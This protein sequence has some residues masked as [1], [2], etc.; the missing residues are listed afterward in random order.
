MDDNTS[1]GGMTVFVTLTYNNLSIPVFS[2]VA[3]A[4]DY[5]S[6]EIYSK[7]YTI[8]CFSK[9]HKDAFEN[10][11]RKYFER[12]GVTGKSCGSP[13]RFFWASEYGMSDSGTHRPHYHLLI[14]FP[15]D[16]LNVLKI[17]QSFVTSQKLKDLI[18]DCWKHGFC[19]WSKPSAGGMFV[20]SVFACTYVSKYV[21]KDI[22]F[23]D[24]PDLKEYLSFPDLIEA[25]R[26]FNLVKDRFPR[27][28]QSKSFG[29]G[30]VDLC[31]NDLVFKDGIN[32][33]F[34]KD[35]KF[36]KKKIYKV[37]RYI[38]RKLLYK[39]DEY[40]S[41]VLNERG[42]SVKKI[43]LSFHDKVDLLTK[44][45]SDYFN[46]DYIVSR[47]SNDLS[48]FNSFSKRSFL[49]PESIISEFKYLLDGRSYKELALY[50]LVYQ[51]TIVSTNKYFDKWFI[52]NFN[53]WSVEKLYKEGEYL[54]NLRVD[55]YENDDFY[56]EDG[57]MNVLNKEKFLVFDDFE[58]FSCLDRFNCL[59]LQLENYYKVSRNTKYLEDKKKRAKFKFKIS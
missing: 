27:H 20:R 29:L 16:Y 21:V 6:G 11:L 17:D 35:V 47:V 30:L 2:D 5:E 14:F 7:L 42:K 19:R 40:G 59:A 50:T 9:R 28:W 32:L 52:K 53:S 39:V 54:Y 51:G 45:I 33:S 57:F 44:H 31:N 1:N 41:L 49:S 48:S 56:D 36:G 22:D 34:R 23:F 10:K 26:R 38:E 12:R 13:I 43:I 46:L 58:R 55:G 4:I 3:P 37:P 25:K 18:Q 24:Q 15:K 8:P